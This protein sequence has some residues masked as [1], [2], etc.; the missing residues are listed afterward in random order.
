MTSRSRVASYLATQLK[1]SN[2]TQRARAVDQVAAWLK[3]NRKTK[4]ID[5]LVQ[6]VALD[7]MNDNGY[8]YAN[9]T[10][11]RPLDA[12]MRKA[13]ELNI[14]NMTNSDNVE[15]VYNV[16]PSIIGGIK[17]QLPNGTMDASIERKLAKIIEN[18]G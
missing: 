18:V 12:K 7:L 13:V 15:A 2:L 8:V 9:I 10:T 17:I 4:E 14:S 16:E 3:S 11:A 5:H 6:D 1:N